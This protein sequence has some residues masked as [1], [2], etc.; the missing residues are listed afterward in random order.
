MMMFLSTDEKLFWTGQDFRHP[1]NITYILLFTDPL[2][3]QSVAHMCAHTHTH[4]P[5]QPYTH[6]QYPRRKGR[7]RR[8]GGLCNIAA[9][10]AHELS[11]VFTTVFLERGSRSPGYLHE[12][13]APS[14]AVLSGQREDAPFQPSRLQGLPCLC[15]A[16]AS[17]GIF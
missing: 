11:A 5:T 13:Q 10:G 8:T 14:S 6:T 9:R 17:T 3:P 1:S 12:P 16:F 15:E 7:G 4:T 2:S